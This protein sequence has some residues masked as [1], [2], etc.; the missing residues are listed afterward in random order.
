MVY[1]K[2]KK[3]V[4]LLLLSLSTGCKKQNKR[5]SINTEN[6]SLYIV[7]NTDSNYC[8]ATIL[9]SL[10]KGSTND[11]SKNQTLYYNIEKNILLENL[12]LIQNNLNNITEFYDLTVLTKS[13]IMKSEDQE[14]VILIGQASG[15]TG[16][17]VDYWNYR[18]YAINNDSFEIK[19]SSLINS[20]LSLFIDNDGKVKHIEVEKKFYDYEN[21]ERNRSLIVNLFK[22][23]HKISSS[24]YNCNE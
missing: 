13:Y 6:L 10:R 3:I 24:Y 19:F 14:F 16:V 20:P 23:N 4:F 21:E 17:G 22:D 11:K 7:A 5:T 9:D 1:I 15:A 8:S 2:A 18:C 12:N